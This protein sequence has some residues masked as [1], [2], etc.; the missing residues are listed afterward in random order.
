MARRN[1]RGGRYAN[2]PQKSKK[3]AMP[4]LL[5]VVGIALLCLIG[6]IAA[7]YIKTT[8]EPGNQIG[9][10][11]FYFTLDLFKVDEAYPE[12]TDE[13][14]IV[15]RQIHLYGAGQNSLTFKVQNFF[16]EF[17][18]NA[19]PI[20]YTV[21]YTTSP[22]LNATVHEE[23]AS[24]QSSYTLSGGTQASQTFYVTATGGV[25][26]GAQVVVTVKS[27]V[28]YTKTM[29]LTVVFHPQ[30][31]DVL[32]RIEDKA[33]DNHAELIIMASKTLAADAIQVD[34]SAING[35]TNALQIDSTNAYMDPVIGSGGFAKTAVS[36]KVINQDE[37]ITV[38]FF[39]ADPSQ[40]YSMPNTPAELNGG[41][42]QVILTANTTN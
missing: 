40:D 19:D 7:K 21:T 39:K 8:D 11:D 36:K 22:G 6:G 10:K 5:A 23:N 12:D 38:Y 41:K 42:Y 2:A 16:D 29:V 25:T 34:W 4:L 14:A 33:G 26:D 35:S 1:K 31:E 18:V 9:A 30:Q 32:Y 20:T 15:A 13:N 3:R 28:P 37:S 27:T 24:V 17:R